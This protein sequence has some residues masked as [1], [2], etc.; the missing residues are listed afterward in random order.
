MS[1][2]RKNP[3]KICLKSRNE[4]V[5]Y[6][7]LGEL[8]NRWKDYLLEQLVLNIPSKEKIL[9]ELDSPLQQLAVF[10]AINAL[11]AVAGFLPPDLEQEEI[12]NLDY[13]YII[14]KKDQEKINYI[15]Q[16]KNVAHYYKK[17]SEKREFFI[18]FSSGSKGYRSYILRNQGSWLR[19]FPYQNKI[20]NIT[21]DTTLLINGSL[22]YTANF[23]IVLATLYVGGTVC[24]SHTLKPASFQKD[25]LFFRPTVIYLVPTVLRFFVDK[26]SEVNQ[27]LKVMV[28][29]GEKL[30][31]K[32]IKKLLNLYPQIKIIEY[33]GASEVGHISYITAQEKLQNPLSVGRLFP[34]VEVKIINKEIFV[35]SPYLSE[36]PSHNNFVATGDLGKYEGDYLYIYGRKGNII[37]RGGKMLS[38]D[39]IEREVQSLPQINNVAAVKIQDEMRG[40]NYI[41]YVEISNL[42]QK[43]LVYGEILQLLKE[44]IR[45]KKIEFIDKIPLNSNGKVDKKYLKKYIM[46]YNF[47][48]F[49]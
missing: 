23:N 40:E 49:N 13:Q 27:E 15:Q 38:L 46:K 5:I 35:K 3:Q 29:A 16:N 30:D 28:T 47:P 10:Y 1:S 32:T 36:V 24:F 8:I 42:E 48:L 41:L 20:F 25:L 43:H 6:E 26:I 9:I 21:E 45:P 7:R 22:A 31:V 33:Y 18:A 34:Q 17:S 37:S 19:A 2:I 39:W 11:G 14:T 44:P 12:K 4:N